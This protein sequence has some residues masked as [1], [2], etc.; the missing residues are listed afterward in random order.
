[1]N[2]II[3][4]KS[5]EVKRVKNIQQYKQRLRQA[6]KTLYYSRSKST[7]YLQRKMGIGYVYASIL[8]KDITKH[9]N[10][11]LLKRS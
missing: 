11:Q 8:L 5:S 6:R 7:S 10:Y 1:M 2:Y 4:Y 9:M 3:R